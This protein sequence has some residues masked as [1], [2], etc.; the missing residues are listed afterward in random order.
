LENFCDVLDN[1]AIDVAVDDYL[2]QGWSEWNRNE[3]GFAT[4]GKQE[5]TLVHH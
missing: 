2:L 3:K 4:S 1:L 5:I